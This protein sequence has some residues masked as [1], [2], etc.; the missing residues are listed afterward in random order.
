M[1]PL[2]MK[3]SITRLRHAPRVSALAALCAKLLAA[4]MLFAAAPAGA[5]QFG[6]IDLSTLGGTT[7]AAFGINNSGQVVG[8]AKTAGNAADHAFLYSGG[9]V[10]DLGTFGGRCPARARLATHAPR[11]RCG[12]H[13]GR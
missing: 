9:G 12:R 5:V 3:P 6:V 1:K 10:T 2:T 11:T 7:S 8:Y 13:P 4:P